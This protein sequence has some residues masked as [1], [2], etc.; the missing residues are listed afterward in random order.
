M[1]AY[2]CTVII[3][4]PQGEIRNIHVLERHVGNYIFVYYNGFN[5][6]D[7]YTLGEGYSGEDMLAY[8]LNRGVAPIKAFAKP[9]VNPA[10]SD[11][12]LAASHPNPCKPKPAAAQTRPLPKTPTQAVLKPKSNDEQSMKKEVSNV[13]QPTGGFF[14]KPPG[15]TAKPN[16]SSA[17]PNITPK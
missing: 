2:K 15:S 8:L 3:I 13:T 7:G 17:K 1:R 4:G 5:H 11:K 16:R 14:K 10:E 6:Y 12:S 9:V